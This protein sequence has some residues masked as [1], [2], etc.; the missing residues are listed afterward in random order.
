LDGN[1]FLPETGMPILKRERKRVTLAVCE[2]DPLIV[3]IVKE[4]SLIIFFPTMIT[5]VY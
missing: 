4:K 3:A 2:P 5:P 1:R